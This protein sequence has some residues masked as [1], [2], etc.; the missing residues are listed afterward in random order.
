M[1]VFSRRTHTGIHRY[2]QLSSAGQEP[3]PESKGP[4]VPDAFA[5]GGLGL[6]PFRPGRYQPG[7]QGRDPLRSQ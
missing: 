3:E 2:E 7:K 6:H 5:A 1:A 4:A